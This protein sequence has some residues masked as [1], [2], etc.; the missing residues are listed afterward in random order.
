LLCDPHTY[1]QK[2]K[3]G[4]NNPIEAAKRLNASRQDDLA[5]GAE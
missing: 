2:R 4:L 5:L 3:V 1:S